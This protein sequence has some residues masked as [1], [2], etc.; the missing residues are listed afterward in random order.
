VASPLRPSTPEVARPARGR[1][2]A[3]PPSDAALDAI[4]QLAIQEDLGA[5]DA[6]SEVV[7]PATLRARGTFVVK[8][9]GVVAGLAVAARLFRRVEPG[10]RARFLVAD[11][12]EVDPGASVM[13]VEGS[14]RA[15]LAGERSA[16]NFVQRL[17][18]IATLTR[19]F[20]ERVEGRARIFDTR[21]TTPGLR[22]VEK[23]AV[24]LGGGENHRFGLSDQAML[25]N[26]HLDLTGGDPAGLVR[27]IRAAKGER[28]TGTVE[29]RDRAE[30]LAAIEGGADV[31]LL[32]NFTPARLAAL[33]PELRARSSAF[34]RAVELEASGGVT[35][36]NVMSFAAS[37]VERISIGALTHSASAL[38][39]SLRLEPRA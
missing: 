6:T 26:N 38:D 20:V 3:I 35:L 9:D 30:A 16:L 28:F 32:D 10:S 24:W 17:S 21:K 11:G 36:D 31:V 8:E 13:E 37:G 5:G 33:V 15:L 29:A 18:G 7:I 27:A 19:R 34:G 2:P 23:W 12:T 39:V 22:A 25:K 4:V 1:T 14:A